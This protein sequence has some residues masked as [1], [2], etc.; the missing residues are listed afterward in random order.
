[1]LDVDLTVQIRACQ[2]AAHKI[3]P[4][5]FNSYSKKMMNLHH[6]GFGPRVKVT[7]ILPLNNPNTA[8]H[9]R[10]SNWACEILSRFSSKSSEHSL[11]AT[12]SSCFSNV[13]KYPISL[14]KK[15]Q[16]KSHAGKD[17]VPRATLYHWQKDWVLQDHTCQSIILC[18]F[19]AHLKINFSKQEWN[20]QLNMSFGLR[21]RNLIAVI[22]MNM[23]SCTSSCV[24]LMENSAKSSPAA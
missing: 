17:F 15:S 13:S 2:K 1:M 6:T 19:W 18:K 7:V 4:E 11:N 22:R 9:D 14:V 21:K 23:K 16:E 24:R 8:R 20:I 5:T 10:T 3:H 12:R